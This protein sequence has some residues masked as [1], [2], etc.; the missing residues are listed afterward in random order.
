MYNDFNKDPLRFYHTS[1]NAEFLSPMRYISS[2]VQSSRMGRASIGGARMG[3]SSSSQPISLLDRNNN[4]SNYSVYNIQVEQFIDSF[5]EY[6]KITD[7]LSNYKKK[8]E[9]RSI[10]ADT[11]TKI[12]LLKNQSKSY[13]NDIQDKINNI[14]DLSVTLERLSH[15]VYNQC[16]IKALYNSKSKI[17]DFI[18]V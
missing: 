5:F 14:S 9:G 2:A 6:E 12:I 16:P 8:Y 17:W 18:L 7:E 4:D 11:K 15:K 10:P 13:Y 1:T 3:A